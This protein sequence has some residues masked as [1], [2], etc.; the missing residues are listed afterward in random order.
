MIELTRLEINVWG[1][2]GGLEPLARIPALTHLALIN[3]D[4]LEQAA[5]ESIAQITGL[6]RLYLTVGPH[7]DLS[8]LTRLP[9]L[10]RLKLGAGDREPDPRLEATLRGLI[11]RGVDVS[12]YAHEAWTK[13]LSLASTPGVVSVVQGSRMAFTN[14]PSRVEALRSRLVTNSFLD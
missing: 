7:V 1:R 11:R 8:V 9:A 4:K 10:K 14:D 5:V 13:A 3:G 2:T 6:T 12:L